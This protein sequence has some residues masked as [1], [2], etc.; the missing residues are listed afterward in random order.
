[1]RTEKMAAW[2]KKWL[3]LLQLLR[4][5]LKA[6]CWPVL[7]IPFAMWGV[8]ALGVCWFLLPRGETAYGQ[9]LSF[10]DDI[11]GVVVTGAACVLAALRCVIQ[12]KRYWLWVT[13]LASLLF[14]RELHFKGS[15][16]L[17]HV[18]IVVVF[19]AAWLLYQ[20]M[21]EY[22]TSRRV[23]TLIVLL[24]TFYTI[25]QT[26][27]QRWWQFLPR[28]DDWKKAVEEFLEVMGHLTLLSLVILSRP[29]TSEPDAEPVVPAL[30]RSQVLPLDSR[31]RPRDSG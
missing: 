28:E 8:T 30:L 12:R 6:I 4:F 25:T 31:R 9:W 18:G 10:W 2:Q 29:R 19:T 24:F 15:N 14:C 13:V 11:A 7:L 23:V 22:F 16:I 5:D 26:L 20:S 1:M 3:Q 17:V 27:D 21:T